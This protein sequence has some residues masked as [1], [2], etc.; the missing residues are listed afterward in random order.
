[1]RSRHP[2]STV[3]SLL[4]VAGRSRQKPVR[5]GLPRSARLLRR[6]W[7]MRIEPRLLPA[8]TETLSEK[9]PQ[10][11]FSHHLEPR[12]LGMRQRTGVDAHP[13]V[14]SAAHQRRYELARIQQA[15][16]VERV[17]DREKR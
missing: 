4:T 5:P 15:A 10:A 8:A 14:L 2:L 11:S 6:L 12:K 1:M 17:F 9:R 16:G 7:R 13:A 3:S